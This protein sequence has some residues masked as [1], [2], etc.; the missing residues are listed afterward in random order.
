MVK[1]EYFSIK[2]ASQ[3]T[4]IPP[5]TLR[6]W[7]KLGIIKP[8]ISEGR[9]KFTL[10][11]IEKI[12]LVKSLLEEGYALKKIKNKLKRMKNLVVDGIIKEKLREIEQLLNQA[13]EILK[14]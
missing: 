7:E 6:Y 4:G 5:Y 10:R 2:E 11:E 13:L 14:K 12:K 1:K 8:E 9:R 3:L